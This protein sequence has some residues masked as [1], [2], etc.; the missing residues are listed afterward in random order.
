MSE[1][2]NMGIKIT[3]DIEREMVF[4][5]N[6]LDACIEKY[7]KME[8]MLNTMNDLEA[9]KWLA[10]QMLN[11]GAEIYNDMH[12]DNKIPLIDET[13]MKRY[14]SG[15]GGIRELQSKV[16]E[17]ILKGLPPEAVAQVEEI[18]KNLIAARSEMQQTQ[19]GEKVNRAQR[20]AK[21]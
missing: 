8:D 1:Q 13:K 11:E 18:G 12:P 21:K 5:L 14:V 6:V 2:K 15:L 20:R 7:G 9:T 4:S 19:S 3:L 10:L 17:A 16:T